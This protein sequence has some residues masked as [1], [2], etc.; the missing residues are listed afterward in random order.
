MKSSRNE[1]ED[2]II[3]WE[4]LNQVMT[5]PHLRPPVRATLECISSLGPDRALKQHAFTSSGDPDARKRERGRRPILDPVVI[6]QANG[7][8]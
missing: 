3:T 4:L 2:G 1:A 6:A 7:S 8:E 5:F